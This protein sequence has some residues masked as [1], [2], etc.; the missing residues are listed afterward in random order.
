MNQHFEN[1]FVL[2]R[3]GAGKSEFFDHIKKI[4]DTERLKKFNIG[5]F[6]TIDDWLVLA[7]KFRED[8]LWEKLT[9]HRKY[10]RLDQGV[11]VVTDLL[12]YDYAV[13][14]LNRL[15]LELLEKNPTFYSERSLLI[16]FSR[17]G[18]KNYTHTFSF[19]DAAILK[20]AAIIY[21]QADMDVCWERNV[22]RYEEKK[23]H[24]VL[25][26]LVPKSQ[27]ERLY[28]EDDWTQLTQNKETGFI[29]VSGQSIPFVT[30]DNN[31]TPL[32]D[33]RNPEVMGPKYEHAMNLLYKTC[34]EKRS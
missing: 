17:G 2:G 29:S 30:L 13:M 15:A 32:K 3:P 22:W 4:G 33:L 24:S 18:E 6:E 31:A 21:V 1:L 7:D 25:A 5:S 10:T 20:K 8:E 16:E 12:L 14:Q 34:Q 26:H 23:K 19:F 28:R 27:L 11:E 9:G